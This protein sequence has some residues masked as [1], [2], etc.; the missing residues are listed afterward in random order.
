MKKFIWL[1]LTAS[2]LSAQNI[3]WSR[4]FDQG[5]D[6]FGNGIAVDGSNYIVVGGSITSNQSDWLCIKYN[7]NG[8]T[9]W[10]KKFSTGY[11]DIATAVAIDQNHN[12]IIV[13][14]SQ[15]QD[16][17]ILII[18]KLNSIGN[19]IWT[20]MLRQGRRT[21]ANG[22]GIDPANNIYVVGNIE[23]NY[24]YDI[25]LI[26]FNNSGDTIWTRKFSTPLDESGEEVVVD[27]TNDIIVTGDIGI[28]G[29]KD[30]L[31]I[32]FNSNG[33][34]LWTRY[35]YTGYDCYGSGVC[36]DNSNNVIVVGSVS[37]NLLT[38]KYD[39]NGNLLWTKI[40]N[41]ILTTGN[42]CAVDTRGDIVVIG[43]TYIG[44]NYDFLLLKYTW[45]GDTVWSR[46]YNISTYDDGNA[47]KIDQLAN[48][49]ITGNIFNNNDY[50][51]TTIKFNNT[52]GIKE[53]SLL[54]PIVDCFRLQLNSVIRKSLNFKIH[55][56]NNQFNS[57]PTLLNI[58]LYDITGY[59]IS[60]IYSGQINKD[61]K[62]FSIEIP[63]AGL[64]FL[65]AKIQSDNIKQ[66]IRRKV[67]VLK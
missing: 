35:Y 42:S 65:L 10:T 18:R 44:S 28:T 33:D 2:L 3:I 43:N 36:V 59:R 64:Y 7:S 40:L 49:V 61:E 31:T 54:K 4:I 62:N 48:I 14:Y 27:L 8:D 37:Q 52:V 41:N 63:R 23:N 67:V 19:L 38:L 9:I 16:S 32:K 15:K 11:D 24:D 58:N 1:L 60:E 30:V 57:R 12:I 21:Y 46:N 66:I 56:T 55:L 39:S 34:T 25:L 17:V 29:F 45:Y 26:K 5:H 50:D 20:K 13:G 51:I 47:I 22:V 6:E 53:Y